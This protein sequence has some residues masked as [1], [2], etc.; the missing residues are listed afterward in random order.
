MK[1]SFAQLNGCI[2]AYPHNRAP[3]QAAVKS[4]L[5]GGGNDVWQQPPDISVG[6]SAEKQS[7]TPET[8]FN[9]EQFTERPL[10]KRFL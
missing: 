8:G 5:P 9:N 3:A 6:A 1:G 10:F 2:F 7:L 4:A